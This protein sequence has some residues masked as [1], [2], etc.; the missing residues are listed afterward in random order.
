[1]KV[2]KNMKVLCT[3]II[4]SLV[5]SIP[6]FG[7]DVIGKQVRND[8]YPLD[9]DSF[10]WVEGWAEPFQFFPDYFKLSATIQ[11]GLKNTSEKPIDIRTLKFDGKKI[12]DVCT[13]F[14]YAGPVIWYRTNPEVLVPGETGFIT[15]RLRKT[16]EKA[17]KLE[18]AGK[19][20]VI[21]PADSDAMRIL[22][23]GFNNARDILH[24]Y[25]SKVTNRRMQ[26]ET[27]LLDEKKIPQK[28]IEIVNASFKQKNCA[29]AKIELQEPLPYGKYFILKAV[30]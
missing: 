27:F 26:L 16:L 8:I 6:A 11:I 18:I 2:F 10:Q 30:G 3:L 20:L 5:L 22:Y 29:Y 9:M 4:C 13:R 17:V 15:I 14:D 19:E 25:V 24:V 28:N 23:V 1:M 7:L 21:T 12:K